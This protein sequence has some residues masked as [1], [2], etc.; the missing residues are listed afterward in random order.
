MFSLKEL[1]GYGIRYRGGPFGWAISYMVG[2]KADDMAW[3]YAALCGRVRQK[4]SGSGVCPTCPAVFY[5]C[6]FVSEKHGMDLSP[7]AA[8]RGCNNA[9]SYAINNAFFQGGPSPKGGVGHF[10]TLESSD[11]TCERIKR[12]QEITPRKIC[13]PLFMNVIS[14][15]PPCTCVSS[16]HVTQVQRIDRILLG[17]IWLRSL[18]FSGKG[19]K[20][21]SPAGNSF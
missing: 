12:V 7:A 2:Q 20:C 16:P 10:P 15:T 3:N 11:K 18:F 5:F 1:L 21:L 9:R 14:R 8:A 19:G 4:G 13:S 6:V 17:I